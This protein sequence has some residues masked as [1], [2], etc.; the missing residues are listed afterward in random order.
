MKRERIWLFITI[1]LALIL[2]FVPGA[3][4]DI[5][6][7]LALPFTLLGGLLRKLSLSGGFGNIAAIVVFGLVSA[8]PL[9]FW[10]R[11]K[12]KA[13][14]WLLVLLSVVTGLVLYYMINPALRHALLQNETGDGVY[15]GVFWSCLM[16]WGVLK[17]LNS[18]EALLRGNIYRA[19]RIF[20]LLCA[21]SCILN[22]FGLRLGWLVEQLRLYSDMAY[23]FWKGPTYFFLLLDFAVTA[24]ENGLTALVLYKG[25]K[26]LGTLEAD[27]FGTACVEA[28]GDVSRWC[29]QTLAI[30]SLMSLTLNIS[31][32][33]M[34]D[35]MLNI[36]LELRIPVFGMA[37]AFSVMALSR[38]LTQGKE[39]KDET[40][41]FI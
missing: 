40:D 11:S 29:R 7:L 6:G 17:L 26:L 31:V 30:V 20:L 3:G 39:L 37:V 36:N 34:S 38:L 35:L 5:F 19:L 41:L 10:F 28:A 18:G 32:L 4:G 14:D 13:E 27:P 21:G 1:V 24:A 23:G 8:V 22:V 25:A 15:A 2:A 12:R 33:L 9:V 16:T